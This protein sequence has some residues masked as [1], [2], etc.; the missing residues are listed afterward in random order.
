MGPLGVH[1]WQA[2]WIFGVLLTITVGPNNLGVYVYT[3]EL[4]P[5]RMRAWA[6][7]TGSSMNRIGSLIAPSM[8]GFLMAT[9]NN[10]ALV[11]TMM[12]VVATWGAFVM[13]KWG[14]ETKR[15]TLEEISP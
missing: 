4:Y 1:S 3:P 7:A 9:Y 2:L 12:A 13:W 5:T 8:V 15:R 11:F 14:E 6:T 10:F